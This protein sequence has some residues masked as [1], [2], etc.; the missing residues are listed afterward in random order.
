[1]KKNDVF[2]FTAPNG[3]EVTAVVIAELSG[4]YNEMDDSI[5]KEFLCYAQN[6]L[7]TYAETYRRK[8]AFTEEEIIVTTDKDYGGV[9]VDYA[10]LPDYDKMLEDYQHQIDMANDYTDKTL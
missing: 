8:N 10:I 5:Y 4:S 1:M 9:I 2:T 7:F 6:R 3:E